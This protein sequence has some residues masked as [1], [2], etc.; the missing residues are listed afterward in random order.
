MREN[1]TGKQNLEFSFLYK[2]AHYA[3]FLNF[4][5]IERY[6]AGSFFV[7]TVCPI[8]C[9]VMNSIPGLYPPD[10][11][12]NTLPQLWQPK[13]LPGIAKCAQGANSSTGEN[14]IYDHVTPSC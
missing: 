14:H 1:S 12:S 5:T 2:V 9:K 10:S 8:H 3:E 4:S 6:R 7:V 11:S 13:M